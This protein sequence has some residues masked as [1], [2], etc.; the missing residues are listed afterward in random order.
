MWY[1]KRGWPTLGAESLLGAIRGLWNSCHMA[2]C[3]YFD[4]LPY[5]LHN[6]TEKE[7]K[8]K[9]TEW[10]RKE[11]KNKVASAPGIPVIER[12]IFFK[13]FFIF[14][15]LAPAR[16]YGQSRARSISLGSQL[17]LYVYTVIFLSTCL[18]FSLVSFA[19]ANGKKTVPASN[20]M[21]NWPASLCHHH[22]FRLTIHWLK[23][24]RL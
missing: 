21:A 24:S 14:F 1:T 19:R 11:E 6:T 9:K 15:F 12:N 13:I 16:I 2:W 17:H 4:K 7:R 20:G 5:E 10:V 8:K 22:F 18:F 3:V 23:Q